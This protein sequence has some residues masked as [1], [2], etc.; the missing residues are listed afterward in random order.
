M[1]PLPELL[2]DKTYDRFFR[3]TPH[4]F[5][6]QLNRL[7]W[8]VWIRSDPG[9]AWRK[10]EFDTYEHALDVVLRRI[11]RGDCYDGAIQSRGRFYLPPV[12][13][14]R[15]VHNGQPILERGRDGVLRPKIHEA[16][17]NTPGELVREYGAHQWC[18][19]C[20][21]PVV[22]SYFTQHHA[23]RGT[24]LESLYNG[25]IRR[26]TLCGITFNDMRNH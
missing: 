3:K 22:F 16:V 21:R 2:T 14:S 8:R 11:D 5:D 24:S 7:A 4:L 1:I 20:R 13:R 19:Y 17:W 15:L 6:T 25:D 18:F 26:C 12:K 10:K 23:F 9:S